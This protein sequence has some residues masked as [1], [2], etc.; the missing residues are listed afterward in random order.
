M[1]KFQSGVLHVILYSMNSVKNALQMVGIH[2]FHV[3][4]GKTCANSAVTMYD[5]A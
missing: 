3:T 4:L 2:A 5:V 1:S